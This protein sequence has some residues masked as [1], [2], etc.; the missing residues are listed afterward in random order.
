MS[1]SIE[2]PGPGETQLAARHWPEPAS[3]GVRSIVLAV[4]HGPAG[5]RGAELGSA[6]H[7]RGA[8]VLLLD[9]L[10][11]DEPTDR[12]CTAE[13]EAAGQW[14]IE[15]GADP[16]ALVVAGLG[17]GGTLAFL[18]ACQSSRFQAVVMLD[19]DVAYPE[20]DAARPV[21]PHEMALNLGAPLVAHFGGGGDAEAPG[22][23]VPAADIELLSSKLDAFAKPYEV[24]RYPGVARGFGSGAALELALERTWTFFDEVL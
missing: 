20:L 19:G 6:L 17:R 9:K 8:E 21:Q 1:T 22:D 16:E 3:A 13:I 18:A 11:G 10:G 24:F 15:R 23:P 2:V 5:D 4:G 14:L 7:G 12:R